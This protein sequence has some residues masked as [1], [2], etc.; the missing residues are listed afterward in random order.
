MRPD[1]RADAHRH[2]GGRG[3]GPAFHRGPGLQGGLVPGRQHRREC[4]RP[5][6]LRVRHHARQHHQLPHG[7]GHGR[8]H[9][10]PPGRP[11]APQDP[12]RGDGRLRDSRR[13]RRR[14]RRG[15]AAG[16]RDTR[17]KPRQGRLQQVP[18]RLARRPE[19]GRGRRHHRGLLRPVRHPEIFPHLVSGVF[20]PLHE[21]RHVRHPRR[22]GTAQPHPRGRRRGQD[23]RPGGV[24]LQIRAGH[25]LRQEIRPLRGRPHLGA[26]AATRLRRRGRAAARRRRHRGHRR[27]LRQR[28]RVRGQGRQDR[29]T[30]LGRPPQALGHLQAHLGLQDQRGRGHPP[31][32]GAGIRRIPGRP[33]SQVHRPGLSHRPAKRRPAARRA[34]LRRIHRHG[35]GI[36]RPGAARPHFRPRPVRLGSRGPDPLFLHRPGLALSAPQGPAGRHPRRDDRHPH[37]GGQPHARRRRQLPR[38]HPGQLQR[39]RDDAPGL[40]GRRSRLRDRH[41]ARR[42]GLGRTRHRHHQ[43]R[44]PGPGQDRRA[45]RLQKARGPQKHHQPRQAH[46]PRAGRGTLHLFLQ[47]PHPRHQKDRPAR[48]GSADFH[49]KRHPVLQPLRQVQAGLPHVRPGTRHA[50]PSAQQEHQLRRAHRSHLLFPDHPRRTRRRAAGTT[51]RHHRPLHRLRQVHGRV[52]GENPVRP[53]GPG[54]SRLP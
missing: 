8:D 10:N 31:V 43:N 19:R 28:G 21:K 38:Q 54:A 48:Q 23:F 33:Q 14:A 47:P 11:P 27:S 52:F 41:Q 53:G 44:L 12:A 20:R 26:A 4:R 50:L 6:R 32:R 37:R 2:Q 49:L 24:Q 5:L 15:E 29:R 46:H 9:R 18:G 13:G 42:R 36:L 7:R 45:S 16:Q 35:A 1:R 40:G 34:G 17:Q 51:S 3:Q 22:G 39:S 25:Q 30:L